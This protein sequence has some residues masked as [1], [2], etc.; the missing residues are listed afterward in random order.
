MKFQQNRG[1]AKGGV[2]KNALFHSGKI[3]SLGEIS[4]FWSEISHFLGEISHFER[5]N[6]RNNALL[7]LEFFFV[8]PQ[9]KS[10]D[11]RFSF[12]LHIYIY[13]ISNVS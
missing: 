12:K 4:H 2:D 3:Y 10:L 1:L 11:A 5:N 9:V 7:K 8:S 13:I 6:V